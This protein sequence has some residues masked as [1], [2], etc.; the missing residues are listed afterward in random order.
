MKTTI[1]FLVWLL[2]IGLLHATTIN[3]PSDQ[4]TIQAGINT[5]SDGDTVL[6]SPGTYIENINFNGKNIVVGSLFLVTGDTFYISQTVIN[7]DSSGHVVS[8]INGDSTT[9]LSGF[10]ITDGYADQGGGIVCANSNAILSN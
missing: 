9:V 2:S 10:T 6:V 4:P 1:S 7:G 8:I 5:A 3:V